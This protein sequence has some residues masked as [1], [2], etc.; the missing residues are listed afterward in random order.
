M[1]K[2]LLVIDYQKDFV[3]GS[4]G[5]KEALGILDNVVEKISTYLKA[6]NMVYFT[7]DTHRKDYL[8]TQEGRNLPV[9][10]C[11]KG[12]VGHKLKEE[13]LELIGD[14]T[15]GTDYII[16]EKNTFGYD[17]IATIIPECDLEVIGVCTDICVVSNCLI[18]KA[19]YPEMEITVD[20]S[21]CAG[22]TVE[23]H[24][25]ALETMRS[26]QIKVV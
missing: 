22:V 10:H 26:C 6:G 14:Y 7:L 2:A 17:K 3:D 9:K 11:I 1:K 23:K 15:F 12:T 5:S 24:M 18:L 20:S 4:L 25:A 21:C 16:M 19:A 8:Q 13:I